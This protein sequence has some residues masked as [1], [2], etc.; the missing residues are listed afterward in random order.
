M[1]QIRAHKQS[2][3]VD[4]SILQGFNSSKRYQVKYT[5]EL[6]Y[7]LTESILVNNLINLNL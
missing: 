7:S 6:T 5:S 1:S 3:R 4:K 2:H